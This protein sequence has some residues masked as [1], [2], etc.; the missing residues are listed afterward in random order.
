MILRACHLTRIA[1]T[2]TQHARPSPMALAVIEAVETS[3][4]KAVSTTSAAYDVSNGGVA[5]G[6]LRRIRFLRWLTRCKNQCEQEREDAMEF[7]EPPN[8]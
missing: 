7:H 4:N 8:A 6:F 3:R 5:H 1:L 2:V